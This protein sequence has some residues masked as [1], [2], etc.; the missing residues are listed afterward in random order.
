MQHAHQASES[1]TRSV[2]Q[3]ATDEDGLKVRKRNRKT[4]NDRDRDGAWHKRDE[5][6]FCLRSFAAYKVGKK[7]SIQHR[8]ITPIFQL[9]LLFFLHETFICCCYYCH[10]YYYFVY[11]P[12]FS[13]RVQHSENYFAFVFNKQFFF[14]YLLIPLSSSSFLS[15]S[16]MQSA[17]PPHNHCSNKRRKWNKVSDRST[18]NELF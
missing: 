15:N 1:D 13:Y 17:Q 8:H 5:N 9:C 4:E 11:L 18:Q 3:W 14:N 2:E 6:T 10:Y 12:S 7:K 16:D